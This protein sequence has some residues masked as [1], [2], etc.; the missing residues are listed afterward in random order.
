MDLTRKA[1]HVS[2]LGR[3]FTH[4]YGLWGERPLSQLSESER[5]V[6]QHYELASRIVDTWLL[7]PDSTDPG[8]AYPGSTP[9]FNSTG[10][11]YP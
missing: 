4:R 11:A 9:P 8:A 10:E 7:N 3:R 5:A 1:G 2:F 6:K